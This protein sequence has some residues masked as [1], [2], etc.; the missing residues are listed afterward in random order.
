MRVRCGVVIPATNS[1]ENFATASAGSPSRSS[2][3]L[4]NATLTACSG[5]RSSAVVTLASPSQRRAAAASSTFSSRNAADF[6]SP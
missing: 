1:F 4:V 3:E 2:P 6:R 5:R